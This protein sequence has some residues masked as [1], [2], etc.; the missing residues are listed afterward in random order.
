M[1]KYQ[2]ALALVVVALVS[3]VQSKPWIQGVGK[4]CDCFSMTFN[5]LRV[6]HSGQKNNK[7]RIVV[8]LHSRGVSFK[9]IV[10]EKDPM[11]FPLI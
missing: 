10:F 8:N 5:N 4:L 2:L 1:A 9:R 7:L 3:M 6:E 11:S